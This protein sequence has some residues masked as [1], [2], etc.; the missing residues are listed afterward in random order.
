MF[1]KSSEASCASQ[2]AKPNE[3]P[4]A[5]RLCCQVFPPSVLRLWKSALAFG[6]ETVVIGCGFF[7]IYR[8]RG[9]RFVSAT[10][11]HAHFRHRAAPVRVRPEQRD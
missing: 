6:S 5:I 7:V 1:P 10:H 4:F 8:H 9:F 3:S 2:Q 11:A